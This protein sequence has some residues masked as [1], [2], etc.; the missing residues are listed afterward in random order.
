MI[1][2]L[3]L[4]AANLFPVTG[5]DGLSCKTVK[6]EEINDAFK[7]PLP[8][9]ERIRETEQIVSM[10]IER[11]VSFGICLHLVICISGIN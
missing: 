1:I 10:Y 4:T 5:M 6:W 2:L 3:S 11:K 9:S 7:M 8:L